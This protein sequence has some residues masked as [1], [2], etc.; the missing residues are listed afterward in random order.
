MCSGFFLFVSRTH[1]YGGKWI[2]LQHSEG[3]HILKFLYGYINITHLFSRGKKVCIRFFLFVCKV[4][5]H[6]E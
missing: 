6:G 2:N 3:I 5:L 4:H 1:L